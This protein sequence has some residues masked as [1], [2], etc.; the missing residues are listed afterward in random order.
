MRLRKLDK[1]DKF[2]PISQSHLH[3]LLEHR[4]QCDSMLCGYANSASNALWHREI[5]HIRSV[6]MTSLCLL[7]CFDCAAR[8]RLSR[9]QM[10]Q[11][12]QNMTIYN[13]PFTPIHYIC[14][15]A[16]LFSTS[17]SCPRHLHGPQEEIP[18]FSA[19]S[20]SLPCISHK[21]TPK[22]HFHVFTRVVWACESVSFSNL[23]AQFDS[24]M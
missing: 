6:I 8:L 13:D 12:R 7:D 23:Q 19:L 17:P 11:T 15:N 4:H 1:I 16:W 22:L 20:N 14:V 3:R 21:Y 9:C 24:D 5:A 10:Q 18:P 2:S